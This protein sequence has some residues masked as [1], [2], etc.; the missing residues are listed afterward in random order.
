MISRRRLLGT[1]TATAVVVVGAVTVLSRRSGRVEADTSPDVA[2]HV[3]PIRRSSLRR[4]VTAY[5]T[6]EP[7]PSLDGQPAGGALITPFTDGVVSEVEMVEGGTVKRGAVLVRLD[8]RLARAALARARSAA[9]VAEKAFQRQE[10]LRSTD[11]TSQK[12][13]LEAQGARDAAR[14]DLSEAETRLAYLEI[15]APLAG[16][17]LDVRAVVG[18]HVDASTV[19]ARVADLNR[20]VVAAGVPAREMDGIAKGL[21]AFLGVGD[22]VPVGTVE[23]VGRSVD[24]ATGTYSVQ[25]SVPSGAGLTPG[26][27][28]EIRIV[29]EEHADV[30]TVPEECLVTRPDEGTWIVVVEGDRAVRH[31]VRAG[32]RDRGL[33]E[34][35]GEGIEEGMRVVTREAY[36]LPSDTTRVRIAGD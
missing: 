7:A 20:L 2:V 34:V 13:Y 35:S 12:A 26:R 17:V 29:A 9:D 22:S 25:V 21:T 30:L 24:P 16:T 15:R 14:A 4:M 8:S 11:G 31:P 18:Q 6:V 36:G 28:T 32:F 3:A 1:A 27:F 10:T 23:V 19:L 33:V 5:G